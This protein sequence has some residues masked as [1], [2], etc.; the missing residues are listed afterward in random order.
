MVKKL[1]I[2]N[3]AAFVNFR[4]QEIEN[5]HWR[6]SFIAYDSFFEDGQVASKETNP[7][8]YTY[9][10]GD[11]DETYRTAIDRFSELYNATNIK[12]KDIQNAF[13][14]EAMSD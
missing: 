10:F 7:K 11:E 3:N 1:I 13:A 5:R 12:V 14:V 8:R 6:F 9:V 4:Y 2:G